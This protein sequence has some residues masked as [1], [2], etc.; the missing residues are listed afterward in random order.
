MRSG[1]HELARGVRG[2]GGDDLRRLAPQLA[3]AFRNIAW[4]TQAA[5][6]TQADDVSR[7]VDGA[8]RASAALAREQGALGDLVTNLRVTADALAA[9]DDHLGD[10]IAEADRLL[11]AAPPAL[12]ALDGAMPV[13]ARV[14]RGVRPALPGAPAS[15]RSS[16]IA[17]EELGSLVAPAARE[18]TLRA[19]TTTFRD[20]PVLVQRLASTFPT[21]KP[22][23]DCLRTHVIPV[24]S[25][26][27][28]DE[29]HSS[30]RP[31]WQDFAHSLVGLSS[32]TQN[33]DGNGYATRYYFGA[34]G[35]IL[36]G[37]EKLAG[38]AATLR[39]RP[40]PP[41]EDPPL[42]RDRPCSTQPVP[43]L[44]ARTG[45]GG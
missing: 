33:F 25:Q 44:E 4:V 36:S 22:L 17:V 21:A 10:T 16:A 31:A 39:S 40:A 24:L 32:A 38:E 29:E 42:R 6:G 45:G 27:V 13:V 20:L 7:L 35:N 26:T 30:G 34:N 15:L 12:R 9:G 3:P 43:T 28:P 11:R 5:Q 41:K 1:L 18:R 37:T 23:A 14:S 2:G 19:L 8:S